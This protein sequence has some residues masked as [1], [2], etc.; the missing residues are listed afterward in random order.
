MKKIFAIAII[1]AGILLFKNNVYA[2]VEYEVGDEVEYN[3]EQ[4]HVIEKSGTDKNYL[5]LLKDKELTVE[6][7]YKYGRDKDGNLFV[8]KY[9]TNLNNPE[10][11]IKEY[12]DGSGGIAYYTSETCTYE[13]TWNGSSYSAINGLY[14]GCKNNY[15]IS[16]VKKVID[17]W[18][19]DKFGDNLIDVDGY[20]SRLLNE[21]DVIDNLGFEFDTGATYFLINSSN[22]YDWIFGDN[23][24]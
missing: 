14:D 13:L 3:G 17:N 8:N 21:S 6:E 23:E 12:N 5:T 1:L 2:Y 18:S 16:D 7:L 9:I 4:Y 22:D 11:V 10:E 15:Q 20:K 24:W 19:K